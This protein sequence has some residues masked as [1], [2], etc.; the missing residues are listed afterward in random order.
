MTEKINYFLI[1][2]EGS[3][4]SIDDLKS[5]KKTAWTGIRNYQA[6]NFMTRDMKVGDLCIFYHSSSEDKGAYGVARVCAE[7]HAD[8][9]QFDK[10]DEHFDPKATKEKP[11]WF[12]VDIQFV[13]KF[14]DPVSLAV[15]K[16]DKKLEGIPVAQRGM[17][18]SVMPISKGDFKRIVELG[19]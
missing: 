7:S 17:R 4:Y 14:K 12:C 2:S 1:K 13:Q 10:K 15:I 6:R 18:L 3:C 11:I 8:I 19:G 9:T 5:D 16:S